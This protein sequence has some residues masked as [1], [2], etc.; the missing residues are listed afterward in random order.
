MLL[1]TSRELICG[2]MV[3]IRSLENL[4]GYF[5]LPVF[6]YWGHWYCVGVPRLSGIIPRRREH[7]WR[8][9]EGNERMSERGL[10][11]TPSEPICSRTPSKYESIVYEVR[12][13]SGLG[14][15]ETGDIQSSLVDWLGAA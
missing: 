10:L 12:E 7:K 2:W 14:Q 8:W 13:L 11:S 5:S 9:D 4:A 6:T 3:A 15:C 1:D